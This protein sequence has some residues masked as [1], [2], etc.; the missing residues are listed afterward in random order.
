MASLQAFEDEVERLA[1]RRFALPDTDGKVASWLPFPPDRFASRVLKLAGLREPSTRL[2]EDIGAFHQQNRARQAELLTRQLA[3][4]RKVAALVQDAYGL[5]P[6]ERALLR[7]TRP[8]RDP[9]DVLEAR[10]RGGEAVEAPD[11]DES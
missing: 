10:I 4:E 2:V 1:S 5:T 7:S 9:L 8:V 6:D 11:N 3:L